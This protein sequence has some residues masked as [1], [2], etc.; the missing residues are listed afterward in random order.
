MSRLLDALAVIVTL[1]Y[2]LAIWLGQGSFEPRVL[3]L[4]LLI[5]LVTRLHAV[6]GSASARW[7]LGG[8]MLL[9]ALAAWANVMLPL[10]LYPVVVNV[11]LL[12]V[13]AY[14]LVVPPSIAERIARARDPDLSM[15]AIVYTRRVTQVW[16][17]FFVANG[18]VALA[19]ALWAPPAVWWLY[20]GFIAYLAIALLFAG[21]YCVRRYVRRGENV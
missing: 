14:S 9:L 17:G 15:A 6:K 3:A 8:T 19:T 13:F 16:C 2:P 1:A 11:V 20:N 10:R 7:W 18:T 5:V 21:E 12:G 4:L